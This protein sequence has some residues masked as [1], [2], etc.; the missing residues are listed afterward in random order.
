MDEL[1]L[2]V[3][4]LSKE[5][6][7]ILHVF[8]IH[9]LSFLPIHRWKTILWSLGV[10]FIYGMSLFVASTSILHK[11]DVDGSYKF[12]IRNDCNIVFVHRFV[13]L[14]FVFV[15]CCWCWWIRMHYLWGRAA[16]LWCNCNMAYS[17]ANTCS[18]DRLSPISISNVLDTI[19]QSITYSFLLS[20]TKCLMSLQ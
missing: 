7:L 4:H 12:W 17:S 2:V 6:K 14:P 19:G 20:R 9:S 3:I 18:I 11:D 5:S 8:A 15:I 10:C 16:S 13:S 1:V